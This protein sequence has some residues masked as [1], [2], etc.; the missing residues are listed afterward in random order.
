MI[1]LLKLKITLMKTQK[2]HYGSSRLVFLLFLALLF[3]AVEQI[4]IV[5]HKYLIGFE[6]QSNQERK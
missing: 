2:L 1:W 5:K 6:A 4:Q 3:E